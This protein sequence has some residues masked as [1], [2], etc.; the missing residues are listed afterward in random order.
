DPAAA[1]GAVTLRSQAVGAQAAPRIGTAP[2]PARDGALRARREDRRVGD[3]APQRPQ[4]ARRRPRAARRHFE[5]HGQDRAAPVAPG[6]L[7]ARASPAREALA[8]G[9]HHGR[10]RRPLDAE[11]YPEAALSRTGSSSTP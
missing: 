6:A 10:G 11:G 1:D 9:G 4:A 3:P 2:W 8:E 7:G 5:R